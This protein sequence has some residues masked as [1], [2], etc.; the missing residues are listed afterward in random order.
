MLLNALTKTFY[1]A[2][3]VKFGL[4]YYPNFETYEI[5]KKIESSSD[6]SDEDLNDAI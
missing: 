5:V 2:F 3:R 4:L 6:S 1:T